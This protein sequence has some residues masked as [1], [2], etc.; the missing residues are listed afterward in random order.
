MVGETILRMKARLWFLHRGVEKLFEGRARPT[1][2]SWPSASAAT[3]RSGTPWRTSMAVEDA[4]GVEVSE[5]DR[6]LRALLLELE[7]LHNHVADL[8]ALAND[9]GFGDRQRA[10]PAPAREAAAAQ[11][12]RRP[13]IG[14]C[15]ARSASAARGSGR[16]L[17]R[18]RCGRV[19]ADVEELVDVTLG[20]SVVAD[21][22]TGTAVLTTEQAAAAR[23][24]SATSP[25]PAA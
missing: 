6:L 10:R 9:V 2:S 12:G 8:G 19:A 1:A 22:F 16:C 17:T 25:A 15:A 20:H 18:T 7:R 5:P 14:C 21:R 24:R 3:P 13:A 4:A 23:A 11:Q